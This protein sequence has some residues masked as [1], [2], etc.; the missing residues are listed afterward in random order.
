METTLSLA[1]LAICAALAFLAL[2]SRT[3]E[4]DLI[5]PLRPAILS[6]DA[7]VIEL[8]EK[9]CHALRSGFTPSWWLPK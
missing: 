6:N 7:T 5:T 3:S 9:H 1:I 2:R 4:I 8:V